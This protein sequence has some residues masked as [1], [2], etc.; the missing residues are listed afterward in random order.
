MIGAIIGDIVGSRFE[1]NNTTTKDFELSYPLCDFTDDTICTIAIADAILRGIPYRDSLLHWCRKYPN[2]KGAYGGRFSQWLYEANPQ[3]YNSWGNGAA[4]RV[5]PV[6]WAFT[7]L[8]EI[9][10]EALAT[11]QPTH[12][13]PE[14]LIG[15]MVVAEAIFKMRHC[16]S[17]S[18][19][20]ETLIS[21]SADNYGAGCWGDLPKRGVFD[22][23]CRGCVPLAL[24]LVHQSTS[25]EDA[26]RNAVAY[27][28]DS[29]TL[30]AIVGSIAEARWGV[31]HDLREEFVQY[32][33]D[34]ML[35]VLTKF[36]TKYGY[37]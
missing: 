2:P 9:Q 8:P 15:A 35:D 7:S 24:C 32:L 27:G 33:P 16:K 1:F 14:G 18:L 5:S 11:A 26:I 13:H 23:T 29:D 36:E 20:S 3:P 19:A 28:G 25:F 17:Y 21:L 10:R 31:P 34:D 4:M 22:E 37:E 6:A 12:N 30:A